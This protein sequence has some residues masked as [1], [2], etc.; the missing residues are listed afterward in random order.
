MS[1]DPDIH[2]TKNA[3]PKLIKLKDPKFKYLSFEA[4]QLAKIKSDERKQTDFLNLEHQENSAS[5]R[6]LESGF[7]H[8]RIED[9]RMQLASWKNNMEIKRK[10]EVGLHDELYKQAN[11]FKNVVFD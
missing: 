4:T 7:H 8:N 5:I 2:S 6:G 9:D 11:F 3:K 10:F 1:T